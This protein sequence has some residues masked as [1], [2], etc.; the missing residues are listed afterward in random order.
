MYCGQVVEMCKAR[1]IFAK[2][3]KEK[4]H[5]KSVSKLKDLF[6]HDKKLLNFK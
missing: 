3:T 6:I 5:K 2:E 1:T 4:D